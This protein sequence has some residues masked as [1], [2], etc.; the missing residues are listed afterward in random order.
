MKKN[1]KIIGAI[2]ILGFCGVAQARLNTGL[3]AHWS[4]DDCTAKDNSKNE[5]NGDVPS[6]LQCIDSEKGKAIYFDGTGAVITI[7]TS[8][9]L[10]IDREL[11]VSTYVS[12]DSDNPDDAQILQKG[13]SRVIWDYGIG[14][15]NSYSSYRS[16]D[17]DWS[18][19]NTETFDPKYEQYHLLTTV[20]SENNIQEP[21]KLYFDGEKISGDIIG[22]GYI[23]IS[24]NEHEF[25]NQ[26]DYPL[27]IGVG[28]PGYYFKGYVDD[29]RIYNRTLSESEIQEL[30]NEGSTPNTEES[31]S[32]VA[33]LSENL[34]IY[35]PQ[36]L[37]Y[38]GE[39]NNSDLEVNLK[40][41]SNEGEG[42][43]WKLDS[44]NTNVCS[45]DVN[46]CSSSYQVSESSLSDSFGKEALNIYLPFI[47]YNKNTYWANLKYSGD[48]KG[49]YTWNLKDYG[50]TKSKYEDEIRKPNFKSSFYKNTKDEKGN[51]LK[52]YWYRGYAPKEF[53]DYSKGE[54]T[55]LFE[56]CGK[57][58]TYAKGNC[59][60]Y[61]KSRAREL[62]KT[63]PYNSWGNATTFDSKAKGAGYTVNQTPIVGAI[64]QA[65]AYRHGYTKYGHVAV[66]EKVN[67]DGTIDI[68][69]SSYAPCSK[70][71]NFLHRIR[72][73]STKDFDNYI[74]FD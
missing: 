45:K 58:K 40:R 22:N 15:F 32:S 17:A 41:I 54:S 24:N 55:E 14:A 19:T 53:Y 73:V 56:M 59:T 26:S 49:I 38:T 37:L 12:I 68:S 72:N 27:V 30:Y 57:V 71:W 1:I 21:I 48:V 6:S 74:H 47:N 29:V 50:E 31:E 5:N 36:L 7:P 3:V 67:S 46:Q 9:S 34:D 35:I 51:Y 20:V 63:V 25:I 18:S 11:T 28:H 13:Q 61:A 66:V 64:A 62:G 42:L 23:S 2:V 69:E 39:G 10:E 4:F 43:K 44:Y 60:W 33:I 70:G 65:N 16:W 8:S 52:G